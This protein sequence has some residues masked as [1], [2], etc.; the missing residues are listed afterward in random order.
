MNKIAVS[1]YWLNAS[2]AHGVGAES[3]V[4]SNL[5]AE[6]HTIL[7]SVTASPAS[8]SASEAASNSFV[9]AYGPPLSTRSALRALSM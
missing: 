3:P 9:S 5:L 2:E 6:M 8:V 7:S 4:S 1:D